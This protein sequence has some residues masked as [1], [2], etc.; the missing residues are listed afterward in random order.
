MTERSQVQ[1]KLVYIVSSRI[2]KTICPLIYRSQTFANFK[3][4][5]RAGVKLK[6]QIVVCNSR[7]NHT[8]T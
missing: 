1:L 2:R 6:M 5:L 4:I 8:G 3:N 7:V